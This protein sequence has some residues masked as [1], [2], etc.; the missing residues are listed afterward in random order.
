MPG[1]ELIGVLILPFQATCEYVARLK[2][3]KNLTFCSI[4]R[5]LS[6]GSVRK[7]RCIEHGRPGRRLRVAEA[8]PVGEFQD[9]QIS[10]FPISD[11]STES[12]R[13]KLSIGLYAW[14]AEFSLWTTLPLLGIGPASFSVWT[15]PQF[16]SHSSTLVRSRDFLKESIACRCETAAFKQAAA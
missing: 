6:D 9:F 5:G 14:W 8:E 7:K 11:L 1:L 3:I 13:S 15:K 10:R 12:Q 4:C 16:V 2:L